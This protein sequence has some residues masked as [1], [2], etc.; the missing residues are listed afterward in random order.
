MQN[1]DTI[2][3]VKP[4]ETLGENAIA[5][6]KK[7]GSKAVEKVKN[8]KTSTKIGVGV[9]LATAAGVLGVLA[10]KKAS[11]KA[12]KNKASKRHRKLVRAK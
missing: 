11:K 7:I 3:A 10:T 12:S 1:K 9:G 8:A 6:V 2:Q 5:E 4:A